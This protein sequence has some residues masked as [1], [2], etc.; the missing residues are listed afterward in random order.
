MTKYIVVTG[1]VLSGLG[2]GITTSSIGTLLKARGVSLTAVKIDPYLNSDAGTMNPFEHGEVFVLN[3]GGEADLD[4]GN[5]ERFLDIPL[6]RDNN[7]TTGKVYKSVIDKERRGDYLGK[8]VQI[9][10]HI[11]NEIREWI[12]RVAKK[13]N[14]DVCLVE[15]G[16][17]VGDIESAPFLEAIRQLHREVGHENLFLIHTSLV[18]VVGAVGEQKTKPT[19]HTVRDLKSIGLHPDMIVCRSA[20]PLH[21]EIREKI[22][23]FCDVDEAAVISA[24]DARSIY[25][26]PL[27]LEEQG[28]PDTI[29]HRLKVKA[30]A[31]DLAPWR[32]LVDKIVNPS[33][34]VTV[35]FVGKYTDLSD[36]YL[37]INE[38]LRHAGAS[39][40]TKVKIAYIEGEDLESDDREAWKKLKESDAILV[41]P[42][43]GSRGTE[44]KIR[45]VQH[46]RENGVPFLGICLGFQLAIVEM[47]RHLAKLPHANSTEM[48]VN[49][50]DPVICILP[51][52]YEIAELGGT[53]RL[54]SYECVLAMG[55]LAHELY[56]R[57]LVSERH[58]HRY[59][60]N[61]EY[62][63]RMEKA[64]VVFSGR[65]PD[66]PIMEVMELPRIQHPYFIGGQFH[67]EFNSRPQKPG[68]LFVGL[69][70][71]ALVEKGVLKA[72]PEP[73]AAA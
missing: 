40:D 66:R 30:K 17:T 27:I 2:K 24:H 18:P 32:E 37:S 73:V 33:H 25:E 31:P 47:A 7:I 14:A 57:D 10:P 13:S 46:A 58:R 35:A 45:A 19:Q 36:S 22:A 9:V 15:V 26:V 65:M 42:G 70:Q 11:T 29:L 54:G 49:T 59:E 51:E 48:D 20:Q 38:A 53:M 4:L 6:T 67:P 41:G 43:F 28:V 8:T 64:G 52:Q 44:G 21:P 61:P 56:G 3:D 34:Q 50:A 68:P 72:G 62:V 16:G 12:K 71:A 69:I 23:S 55:S 5:Y 60:M 1:G 39:L 63:E